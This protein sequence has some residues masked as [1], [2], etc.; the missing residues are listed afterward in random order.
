MEKEE[1]KQM[2][3]DLPENFSIEELQYKLYVRSKIEKGLK[4]L[5]EGK[6]LT[7]DEVKQRMAQ[8]LKK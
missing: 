2:I 1:L 4:D 5:E 6:T 8:W 3:D 7:H